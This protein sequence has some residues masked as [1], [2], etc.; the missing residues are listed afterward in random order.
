MQMRLNRRRDGLSVERRPPAHE[1][2]AFP[3]LVDAHGDRKD[4]GKGATDRNL[5]QLSG[6]RE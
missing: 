1:L 4:K 6:G 2:G 5:L 3:G